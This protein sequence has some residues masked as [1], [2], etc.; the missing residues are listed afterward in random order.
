[1]TRA[2]HHLD[3]I[4]VLR[5][6]AVLLVFFCHALPYV[7]G[8]NS[9]DLLGWLGVA[10]FFV[11]SGFCIHNSYL[12]EHRRAAQLKLSDFT[13]KFAWRRF[14]RIYPPYIA[15]L[16][17]FWFLESG[18]ESLSSHHFWSHLFLVHN[19][20]GR[21]FFSINPAFWSLAIEWQFYVIYPALLWVARR[22]G[23][24]FVLWSVAGLSFV[25]R[26][27][28]AFWKGFTVPFEH[29]VW[30][31]TPVLLFEWS[32]GVWVAEAWHKGTRLRV[33]DFA[34][35]PFL[36]L[37]LV[38]AFFPP[39][40]AAGFLFAALACV[41]LVN[42]CVRLRS[43]LP[44]VER[45]LAPVGIVSYSF[46]LFHQPLIGRINFYLFHRGELSRDAQPATV[47]ELFM[48]LAVILALSAALYWFLEKP[49]IFAG[50]WL[51]ARLVKRN[52]HETAAAVLGTQSLLK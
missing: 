5:A 11:I 45:A 40:H 28:A 24:I 27:V 21:S 3:R 32:L 22:R 35:V 19:I 8:K 38:V 46:Y 26:V 50:R 6:V 39:A 9:Y 30:L 14:W 34:S 51:W 10:L 52:Q 49:G 41:G 16:L 36:A 42:F 23:I 47:P 1:M 20:D 13:L 43:S 15:A 2:A 33:F 4:D 7:T 17:I 37:C 44:L 25:L 29:T 18:R 48:I 12:E 31:S